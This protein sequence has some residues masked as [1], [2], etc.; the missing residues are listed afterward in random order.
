MFQLFQLTEITTSQ[1]VTNHWTH[2]APL[3]PLGFPN[4]DVGVCGIV[5]VVA[6]AVVAIAVVAFVNVAVLVVVVIVWQIF[7]G[8][9]D[10][11]RKMVVTNGGY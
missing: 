4:G 8:H 2:V 10:F 3:R 1:V 9:M 6:I 7:R 11:S 5:A